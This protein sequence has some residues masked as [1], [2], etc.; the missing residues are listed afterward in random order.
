MLT[1]G[2]LLYD[3]DLIGRTA[4]ATAVTTLVAIASFAAV[5]LAVAALASSAATAQAASIAT[6]VAVAFL[7]G[8][9]GFGDMPAWADRIAAVFPVKPFNDSLRE[10]FN[11]YGSGAGWDVWAL[12]VMA[13]WGLA[14]TLVATRSFR[15]DPAVEHAS[16]R[17]PPRATPPARLLTADA[18][19]LHV[20]SSGRRGA[21]RQLF[22][23]VRWPNLGTRRNPGS[24]FFA[25]RMP[26]TLFALMI[27]VYDRRST[28]PAGEPIDIYTLCGLASWG[29]A[30]V[31]FVYLPEAIAGA[32]ETGVLKRLRGTPLN[33]ALY[34]AGHAASA[35][36]TA[37]VTGVLLVVEGLLF[38]DL[39][40]ASSGLPAAGDPGPGTRASP[41]RASS[42][43]PWCRAARPPVRSG[44]A[45]SS[46]CRSSRTC[47]SPATCPRG[48]NGGLI[49][50]AEA[51]CALAG[52]GTRP[53]GA[54]GELDGRGRD[55][56]VAGARSSPRRS[57]VQAGA[58]VALLRARYQQRQTAALL[59]RA[60]HRGR[61]P[62]EV[63]MPIH[64]RVKSY[65]VTE[66]Q[67]NVVDYRHV[68]RLTLE[69]GHP[70][71][72]GFPPVVPDPPF[73]VSGTGTTAYLPA[74]E[75]DRV[76]RMLQSEQPLFFTA[77]DL[78]GL[79]TVNLSS[80]AEPLGEGPADDSALAA[81]MA[82]AK[83]S[84]P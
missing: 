70:V 7:S 50:A 72:I 28:G 56:G 18:R 22:D 76:W 37:L 80:D 47:S 57:P 21:G 5:G 6:T 82:G 25:A 51:P 10:Q 59:L 61:S 20:D 65:S 11:P 49:A 83:A 41:Q 8:L 73:T 39:K 43:L 63:S 29:A 15:W 27:S 78:F 62:Q 33:P 24:M 44:S 77:L 17:Q 79:R 35:L 81:A 53:G 55:D 84:A 64:E 23:Q 58:A 48:W 16:K 54:I 67:S 32:R 14:A 42:S 66:L 69:S 30:V 34:L 38:F 3:V 13:A 36:W 12:V 4:L 74:D 45:S 75:F 1:V 26:L 60:T 71:F 68:V 40:I 19:T 31:G 46:P 2:A 9:M 52:R